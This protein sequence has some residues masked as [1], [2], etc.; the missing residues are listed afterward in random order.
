MKKIFLFAVMITGLLSFTNTV[1]AQTRDGLA[2]TFPVVAGDS[3]ATADTVFKKINVT[4]GYSTIGIQVSIKKGTGTLDGKFFLY[5]S[6]SGSYVLSDS[7]SF[8]AVPTH[9]TLI[10]NGGYTHTAIIEK[11]APAGTAYIVAAT[12]T[13][14]LTASPV[15]VSYTARKHD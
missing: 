4:A 14:S 5:K 1:Q 9:A 7:A 8:T 12:Q 2:I 6:V 10:S 13:G 11:V 3:L 15:K